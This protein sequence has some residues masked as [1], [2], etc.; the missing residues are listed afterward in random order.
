MLA[1]ASRA[2]MRQMKQAT[3][4]AGRRHGVGGARERG[5]PG[6]MKASVT[7]VGIRPATATVAPVQKI[8]KR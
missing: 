3:S 1:G 4:G 7:S 8:N 2:T 6:S 5:S